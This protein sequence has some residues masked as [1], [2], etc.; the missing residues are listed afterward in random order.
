MVPVLVSALAA[1]LG[2]CGDDD[3]DGG[4]D[5][6]L[7]QKADNGVATCGKPLVYLNFGPVQIRKGQ[8][9]DSKQNITSATELPDEG[10]EIPLYANAA[11]RDRLTQ[12]IDELMATHKVPVVHTRPAQ[13]DYFMLVFVDEFLQGI[14]GGRTATNCG[15]ANR[16]TIGFVNTSFY[17]LHGG[18]DYALHGSMLMLGRSVGADPVEHGLARGNCMVNNEFLSS[19]S[20]GEVAMTN[21]PC[22]TGPQDQLA[23]L[24]AL[25]CP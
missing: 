20:F 18:I 23:L 6:G 14:Q 1:A 24:S 3:G 19:C 13:G 10:L 11:D 9:D 2:G 16:N 4:P 7:E 21:G 17:S 25:A 15:H 22:A 5:D 8:V 12:L